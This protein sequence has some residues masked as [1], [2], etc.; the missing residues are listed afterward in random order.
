MNFIFAKLFEEYIRKND[1]PKHRITA[2]ISLV[3]F[4]LL[5]IILLPVKIFIDKRI[6]DNQLEYNRSTIMIIVFGLLSIII[7]TVYSIYIKNERIFRLVDKYKSKKINK[8]ILYLII[9]LTPVM[10]LLLAGLATVYLNG[11][12][13]LGNEINGLLE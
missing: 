13:I 12:K 5:F 9:I 6:F 10:L 3:Y 2:Y 7:L 4:F 1:S 8:G 11:G